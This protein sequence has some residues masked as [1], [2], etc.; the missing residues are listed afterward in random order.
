[1][2]SDEKI[3]LDIIEFQQTKQPNYVLHMDEK[4]FPLQN[5]IITRSSTPVNRPTTRGGVYFS[6]K[7]EFKI[8]A[9]VK[10]FSIIPLLSKSMLGPNTDF[11]EL[12]IITKAKLENSLKQISLYVN[13]TDSMQSSAYVELNM[14][15]VR[16]NLEN[17]F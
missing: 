2:K 3:L 17:L 1:M 9:Q 16:I 10:D 11:K 8:K 7:Y 15:I 14:T 6:E 5:A 12:K 4:I 13:L